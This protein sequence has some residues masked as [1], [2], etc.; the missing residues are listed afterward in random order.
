MKL[1][2]ALIQS[3]ILALI[4]WY[5][6]DSTVQKYQGLSSLDTNTLAQRYLTEKVQ[7]DG[8]EQPKYPTLADAATQAEKDITTGKNLINA[9]A[10]KIG[11]S[12]LALIVGSAVGGFFTWFIA[13]FIVYITTKPLTTLSDSIWGNFARYFLGPIFTITFLGFFVIDAATEVLIQ[14]F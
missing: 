11:A 6:F 7:E 12:R 4:A 10:V 3:V 13:F 5:V 9:G 14:K 1:F 8:I 2:F